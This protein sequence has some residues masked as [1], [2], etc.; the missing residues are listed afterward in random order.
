MLCVEAIVLTEQVERK[1]SNEQRGL[2]LRQAACLLSYFQRRSLPRKGR[3]QCAAEECLRRHE[4]SL[5][6]CDSQWDT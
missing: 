2:Q 1:V 5:C 3:R 4:K 6:S